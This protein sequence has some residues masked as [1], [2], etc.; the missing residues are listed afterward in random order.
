MEILSMATH[1]V[2]SPFYILASLTG[3][4]N[5]HGREYNILY[6][7]SIC[8]ATGIFLVFKRY[9][10]VRNRAVPFDWPAPAVGHHNPLVS[11]L[12]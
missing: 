2:L 7:L 8:I 4:Y 6:P 3:T 1:A 11:L 12:T 5:D 9:E 10:S